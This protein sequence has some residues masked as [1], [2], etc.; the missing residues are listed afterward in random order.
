[1]RRLFLATAAVL[2]TSA[3][4]A[5]AAPSNGGFETGAFD[6]WR[7]L[8]EAG[9]EMRSQ[10]T[11]DWQVYQGRLKSGQ[12]RGPAPTS[13]PRPPGGTFA[14]GLYTQDPG[15][16][17]LHRILSANGP[18]VLSLQLAYRNTNEGGVF[19]A[20]NNLRLDRPNQ[21]LRIDLMKPAAPLD[22]FARQDIIKTLFTTEPGDAA[23]R[24]YAPIDVNVADGRFRLRIAEVDNEGP[25]LVGVDDVSLTPR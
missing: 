13:L 19:I 25:F 21:Q 24:S 23:T 22:S 12:V 16:H 8:D 1:M 9:G 10:A 15:R 18:S 7:T 3:A 11:G 5:I 20:P 14:A 6:G 4:F 2:A 17:I